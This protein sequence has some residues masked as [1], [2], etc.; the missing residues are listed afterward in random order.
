MASAGGS[1]GNKLVPQFLVKLFKMTNNPAHR[2]VI[3]WSDDGTAFWVSDI[4]RFSRDILP[5]YFKHN[6][7]AS[8]VRQLNIYG[9]HRNTN[10]KGKVQVGVG[11]IERF[12]NPNFRLGREDLLVN[13]HRKAPTTIKRNK[14]E[15]GGSTATTP[16]PSE[17]GDAGMDAN[18]FGGDGHSQLVESRLVALERQVQFLH[19]QNQALAAQSARQ[20]DAL[21]HVM[22]V[23]SRMTGVDDNS[24]GATGMSA[25]S[26]NPNMGMAQG[27]GFGAFGGPSQ[28]QQQQQQHLLQQQQQHRLQQQQQQFQDYG[29][30]QQGAAGGFSQQQQHHHQASGYGQDAFGGLSARPDEPDFQ[31]LVDDSVD[32]MDLD[33]MLANM[34]AGQNELVPA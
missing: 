28:Q 4:S 9:F 11:M 25:S 14:S 26:A 32:G 16:A 30:P 31:V 7:Y 19:L 13:I 5:A 10:T 18:T 23:V 15:A 29:Q 8:F 27:A 33:A 22:R 1:G 34:D 21:A 20:Q 24:G 3:A 2:D 17:A 6:N 12:I